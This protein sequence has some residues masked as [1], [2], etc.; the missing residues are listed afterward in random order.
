MSSPS[1]AATKGMCRSASVRTSA[2]A[3]TWLAPS[4]KWSSR[5]FFGC[6]PMCGWIRTVHPSCTAGSPA[7]RN[8]CL[9]SGMSDEDQSGPEQVQRNGLCEAMSPDYFEVD[10][11]GV[12]QFVQ[13]DDVA[14]DVMDE[15]DAAVHACPTGA[16]SRES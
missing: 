8:R 13:G 9:S 12:L 4:A 10:D 11:G 6:C 1:T 3:T 16:L 5:S 7:G 2:S 15:I 14:D